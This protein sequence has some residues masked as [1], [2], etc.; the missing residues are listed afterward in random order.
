MTGVTS[1]ADRTERDMTPT[2]L[3]TLAHLHISRRLARREIS[4]A[5]ANLVRGALLRFTRMYG[6][7]PVRNLGARHVERWIAARNTVAASTLR[8]EVGWLRAF[9][10]WLQTERHIQRHPMIGIRAPRQPRSVPRALTDDERAALEAALPDLRARVVVALMF[11]LGMRRAEVT[12]V[13]LG[14]WDRRAGVLVVTGKGGHQRMLP[15]PDEV[16]RL[17]DRYVDTVRASAGTL[18]RSLDG[19][20]PISP[21]HLGD[22]MR[23][24]MYAAGIKRGPRDGK[25]C[26]SLRHTA[27]S[28]LADVEPD[29]RVIREFLGHVEL[30]STQIYLRRIGLA[31]MREAMEAR[32]AAHA[33]RPAA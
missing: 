10:T 3:T 13:E 9:C 2:T 1:D 20:R 24:W 5:T 30:T 27:A 29:L 26:H 22:L 31:K 11:E 6:N 14:D 16:G 8:N 32:H 12:S 15:V 4:P 23:A 28:D 33:I 17:L 19:L 25:G 18:V 21:S 7:R